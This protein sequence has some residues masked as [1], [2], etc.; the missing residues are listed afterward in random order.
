MTTQQAP[1]IHTKGWDKIISA[2]KSPLGYA[3]LAA[4]CA[5]IIIIPLSKA[6]TDPLVQKLLVFSALSLLCTSIFYVFVMSFIRPEALKGERLSLCISK[7]NDTDNQDASI[8][9]EEGSIDR[10]ESMNLS[11]LGICDF[12]F[13]ED[14]VSV[15]PKYI[16]NCT[17][18]T[19]MFIH[20]RR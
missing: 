13:F 5:I 6:F 2:V 18:L 8:K 16:E 7:E 12:G 11:Q 3:V 10:N 17:S 20:S 4:L 9:I 14:F 19:A 15:F 1:K